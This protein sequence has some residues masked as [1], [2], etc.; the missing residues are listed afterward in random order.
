MKG[1]F[2]FICIFSYNMAMAQIVA[3]KDIV[4]GKATNWHG[5]LS[6]LKLD[7]IYPPKSNKLPLNVYVHGGAFMESSS[8][9]PSY[10]FCDRLSKSGF[11]VAN[12]EYRTGFKQSFQNYQTEISK[13][14]YRAQ[15]D[16]MAA[17]R[18]LVHFANN[19][20]IDTSLIFI[21]GESAGA[22]ASLF[23][24]YVSQEDWDHTAMNLHSSL[25]SV[26]DSGN[27]F[28][29][30]FTIK[31]VIS[32]WGGISDTSLISLHDMQKIP[33]LLFHS[34]DDAEIP[35]EKASHKETRQ[36]LLLGSM[37]IAHRFRNNN[38]CYQLY[39]IRE[40]GHSYGFSSD[41]IASAVKNFVKDIHEEKCNRLEIENKERNISISFVDS[42]EA[43]FPDED[44]K[45]IKLTNGDLQH[46]AGKYD[47]NGASITITVEG[48]H[49]KAQTPEP[50]SFD[51]YPLSE[52]L[53][54]EKSHNYRVEFVKDP[55][56][57]VTEQIVRLTKFRSYNFKKIE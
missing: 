15:Q 6:E 41:Y 48:D 47:A 9:D 25:G 13:A 23:S 5:Q 17:I 29:D 12:V 4:Y 57:K 43:L 50:A 10:P 39:F 52:R 31:G 42:D 26:N 49:L 44:D 28:K 27:E 3:E 14:V 53:F 2:W 34:I 21:A 45:V 35:F 36:Q 51:L 18:F 32:L 1:L 8:K 33:V 54:L 20:K 56:D 16:E 37:D 7:I 55:N 24:A 11:V 38:S 40:A 30:R 22:V 46:F 19:Y